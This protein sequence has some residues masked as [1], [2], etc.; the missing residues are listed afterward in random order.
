MSTRHVEAVFNGG[1]MSD[2]QKVQLVSIARQCLETNDDKIE[3][4]EIATQMSQLLNQQFEA[5]WHVILG[6]DFGVY[7]SA[8]SKTFVQFTLGQMTIVA[9]KT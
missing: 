1:D 4:Q 8:E 2:E 7:V 5:T 9:W 6:R 3:E